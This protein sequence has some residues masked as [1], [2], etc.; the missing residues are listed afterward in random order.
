ML[1]EESSPEI[2]HEPKGEKGF[3]EKVGKDARSG[4]GLVTNIAVVSAFSSTR[5]R[6]YLSSST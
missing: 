5:S 1:E 6:V 2:Q 4:K 3:S